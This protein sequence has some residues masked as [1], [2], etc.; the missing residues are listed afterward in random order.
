M[1]T[2][3]RILAGAGG[4]ANPT[5]NAADKKEGSHS[6]TFDGVNDLV[7]VTNSTSGGFPSDGLY[8]ARTVSVWI[9]P[10]LTTAKYMIFD[11]GGS[12]NGIALRIDDKRQIGPGIDALLNDQAR[13]KSMRTAALGF[14]KPHAADDIAKLVLRLA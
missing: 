12:D 5:F 7:N 8:S 9:K 14:S 13:L 2:A 3:N 4:T 1:G 11:F 10:T 6:L